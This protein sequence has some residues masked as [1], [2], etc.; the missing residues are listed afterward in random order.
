MHP[1]AT[2]IGG[3]VL[4]SALATAQVA[5]AAVAEPPLGL[6]PDPLG[7]D[8]PYRPR[9]QPPELPPV[10]PYVPPSIEGLVQPPGA[11]PPSLPDAPAGASLLS[12]E[13]AADRETRAAAARRAEY[14]R[15]LRMRE[16]PRSR[17]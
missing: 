1:A 14:L 4:A 16:A 9:Y 17:R 8:T 13:A 2:L 15:Q 10:A 5:V 7:L 12:R 11:E 6:P 3:L